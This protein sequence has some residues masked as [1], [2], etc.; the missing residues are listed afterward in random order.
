MV[1]DVVQRRGATDARH[2][3]H[4]RLE[5]RGSNRDLPGLL[6]N[7]VLLAQDPANARWYAFNRGAIA[8]QRVPRALVRHAVVSVVGHTVYWV[9]SSGASP[10]GPAK[11]KPPSVFLAVR[12]AR[13]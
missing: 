6:P 3:R 10:N 2:A 13:Y 8:W 1:A 12:V 9:S 4:V 7:G 5:E 11:P